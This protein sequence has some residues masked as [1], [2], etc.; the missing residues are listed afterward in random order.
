MSWM[1]CRA[2]PPPATKQTHFND[3]DGAQLS[4]NAHVALGGTSDPEV[5]DVPWRH[6]EPHV[7]T[8][9]SEMPLQ[10]WRTFIWPPTHRVKVELVRERDKG[11]GRWRR[12]NRKTQSGE[13]KRVAAP[14][15]PSPSRRALLVRFSFK[16]DQNHHTAVSHVNCVKCIFEKW[17]LSK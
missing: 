11:R 2:Y 15:R 6:N 4:R 14:I 12:P 13:H 17:L 1:A 8:R 9:A 5:L 3:R 10:S 16:E 7:T